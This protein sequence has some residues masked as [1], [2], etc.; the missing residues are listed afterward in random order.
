M[1]LS[2]PQ[3]KT[4]LTA[5]ALPIVAAIMADTSSTCESAT[6][7]SPLPV[8]RDGNDEW[9]QI[10]T[11]NKYRKG[12]AGTTDEGLDSLGKNIAE[13]QLQD[14]YLTANLASIPGMGMARSL[15]MRS[16]NQSTLMRLFV[17]NP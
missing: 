9:L 13:L 1:Y 6:S 2:V 16:T 15:M 8:R 11:V 17:L 4:W 7:C 12:K 5:F 3:L 10:S 14:F